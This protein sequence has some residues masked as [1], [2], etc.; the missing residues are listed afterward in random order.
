VAAGRLTGG[1]STVDQGLMVWGGT[2]TLFVG[3]AGALEGDGARQERAVHSAGL[4]A[5]GGALAGLAVEA[6]RR[7]DG[8]RMLAGTLIGA[9]VGAVVGGVYGALSHERDGSPDPIPL[10]SLRIPT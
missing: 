9:T 10:F 1:L 7:G 2:F 4:G 3:G 8:P 6:A 5:A